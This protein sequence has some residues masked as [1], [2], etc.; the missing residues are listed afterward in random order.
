MENHTSQFI[1]VNGR[2]LYVELYGQA[3]N[4][5]V[6]FLHQ[7]LGA[8]ASWQLQVQPFAQAGYFI[9]I[10]DRWGYGKSDWRNSLITPDFKEDMADLA[11]L[12]DALAIPRLALIGHSD[13]GTLALHF[14]AGHPE[15]VAC[16]VTVAAHVYAEDTMK[17]GIL[18]IY[19]SFYQNAWFQDG[20]RRLHGDKTSQVLSNWYNGWLRLENVDWD[21]RPIIH[22]ISC[23]TLVIQG[24]EDEHAST[25]HARDIAAAI[26]GAKL[27]LEPGAGH[28]VPQDFP[29]IFNLKV[30]EFLKENYV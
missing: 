2:N 28:M 5:A 12:I 8:T 15:T 17:P 4:P 9:V 20:L 25:Q 6:I 11:G 30:L 10:Y 1:S 21:I 22:Q 23:P 29:D 14:A 3:Q 27:W 19:Q 13:G 16:L 26:P 7:G 18:K 24:E